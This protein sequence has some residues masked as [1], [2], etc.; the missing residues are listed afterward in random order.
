[1]SAKRASLYHHELGISSSRVIR[2]WASSCLME[3]WH[4]H[5][6]HCEATVYIAEQSSNLIANEIDNG[7]FIED[8]L[9]GGENFLQAIND[10]KQFQYA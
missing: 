7:L 5:S 3:L 4:L 2:F 8:R 9:G 1:M 10:I 6:L